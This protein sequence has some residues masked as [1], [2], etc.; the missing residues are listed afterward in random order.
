MGPHF[1]RVIRIAAVGLLALCLLNSGAFAHGAAEF[2]S[3][4]FAYP[5]AYIGTDGNLYVTGLDDAGAVQITEDRLAP[6]NPFEDIRW[7]AQ[8]SWSPDGTKLAYADPHGALYIVESGKR[9][10]QLLPRG[11]LAS[12]LNAW[13]PDSTALAFFSEV[14]PAQ[15]VSTGT[16]SVVDVINRKV[17]EVTTFQ[18]TVHGDG[19]IPASLFVREH[20]FA[21]TATTYRPVL[22]WT[23]AGILWGPP[24][25]SD[26]YGWMDV[27]LV[28]PAGKLIREKL[29]N[30]VLSPDGVRALIGESIY[31]FPTGIPARKATPPRVPRGLAW[32]PDGQSVFLGDAKDGGLTLY[33][34]SLGGSKERQV[35]RAVGSSFGVFSFPAGSPALVFSYIAFDYI[36]GAHPQVV[37]LRLGG[38]EPVAEWIALG[39]QPALNRK[40]F[41]AVGHRARSEA[42]AC[43]GVPAPR[44]LVGQ[45]AVVRQEVILS[46]ALL[47]GDEVT[48]LKPGTQLLVLEGP[49]CDRADQTSWYVN[50][51]G[52]TGWVREVSG[53]TYLLEP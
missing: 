18:G 4:T 36:R 5:V 26:E 30:P 50:V 34:R 19:P 46:S 43:P 11:S 31:V 20:E 21:S 27:Q 22:Q 35:F 8:P 47:N 25:V 3:A 53:Q 32:A 39:G 12:P 51:N 7:N 1:L 24:D 45:R 14:R 13:A 41:V 33:Q 28:T 17:S 49:R 16:L 2:D 10:V 44:L 48:D 38:A 23:P 6:Y 37:A 15:A 40:P 9:P 29:F 52:R 42:K